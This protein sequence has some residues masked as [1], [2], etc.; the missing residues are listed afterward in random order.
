MAQIEIDE[1]LNTIKSE[2]ASN[3]EMFGKTL[4]EIN[5]KLEDIANDGIT[6]DL[7]KSSLQDLEVNLESRYRMNLEKF[8]NIKEALENINE[9]QE[10][11]TKNSDLKIMFNILTENID[12][13]GQEIN[14]QKNLINDVENK[15]IEFRNDNSKKDE[16][17]DKV[18]IVKDGI[19]EVN[20]GLQA[21]IMEVNSSLRGITK[22]LMTMD[23]TDQNDIIKRELENIYLATNAILSSMEILDQK[24]DD[25]AKNVLVKDDLI[26]L[27][28]KIDNSFALVSEKIETLDKSGSI[29]SEI[30]KNRDELVSF[31]ENVSK[32]LSEYLNSVRDV[33]SNCIDEIKQ[34]QVSSTLED[35]SIARQKFENLEKLSD[36]I[37]KIDTTI[38]SQSESYVTLISDKIR[39]L[40]ASIDD[41]KSYIDRSHNGIENKL[42]SKIDALDNFI[43]KFKEVFE[44]KFGELHGKVDNSIQ[45]IE[46]F[47]SDSTIKLG[48]S[49]SE[50]VDIKAEISRILENMTAFNSQQ[51]AN[52]GRLDGKLDGDLV[53]LKNDLNNFCGSFEALKYTLEQS[54]LDNREILTEIVDNAAQ[55]TRNIL[56]ELKDFGGEESKN[57]NSQLEILKE[58]VSDLNNAF[59]AIS[60]KNVENILSNLEA[61]FANINSANENLSKTIEGNFDAVRELISN[62]ENENKTQIAELGNSFLA[63][64]SKNAENILANIQ[65]SQNKIDNLNENIPGMLNNSLQDVKTA[66]STSTDETK[67]EI[68]LLGDKFLTEAAQNAGNILSGI[69]SSSEKIDNLNE[70]ITGSLNNNL[71]ELKGEISANAAETKLQIDELGS[72][73]SSVSSQNAENILSH[74]QLTSEKIT[75]LNSSLSASIDNSLSN[76]QEKISLALA[77]NETKQQITELGDKFTSISENNAGNIIA[78]LETV[79][80]RMNRLG[81]EITTELMNSSQN[82]RDILSSAGETTQQKLDEVNE[83]FITIAQ[84]NA[85]NILSSLESTS[86]KIDMLGVD[87][88]TEIDNNFDMVRDFIEFSKNEKNQNVVEYEALS[89]NIRN[90]ESEFSRN[91]ELFKTALD[92]QITSLKDYIQTLNNARNESKNALLF[93]KLAEKML[94][95]ETAIHEAGDNFADN[96][97][98]VQNKIADYAESLD[99]VSS[100]T[101][102]KFEASITEISSVKSELERIVE[103]VSN[104]GV[105]TA[106]RVSETA[107]VLIEKFDEIIANVQNIKDDVNGQVSGSLH[108]NASIID[109]KFAAIQ[110]LLNDNNLRNFDGI[111]DISEN[112]SGKIENLKQETELIKTDVSEIL[113]SKTDAI[114]NEFQPLKESI[115]N[116]LNADF[117]KIIDSIK[118]QIELSYLTFSADVNENLTENHDNYVQLEE[119]YKTLTDKFSKV[120]EIVEDLT[121][122]QIG[123]MT[124]TISEIENNFST[125]LE[126]TNTLLDEWKNDLKT[127]ENKIEESAEICKNNIM[128]ELTGFIKTNSANNKKDILEYLSKLSND[129]KSDSQMEEIINQLKEKLSTDAEDL[130]QNISSLHD[131]VDVLAM[132]DS[133]ENIEELMQTLQEKIED[134][135]EKSENSKTTESLQALHDKIDILAMSDAAETVES[136]IQTLQDKIDNIASSGDNEK[137][138]EMIQA[139]HDK[140]DVLVLS[141]DDIKL[142]YIKAILETLNKKIDSF[143]N[144]DGGKIEEMVKSLHDKM[145]VLVTADNDEKI[146][147]LVQLI[148]D[149]FE[150]IP[151]GSDNE[152]KIESMVQALHDKV[153]VLALSD[154]SEII[155]EIQ[156]IKDLIYEQRKQIENF[157]G[158]ERSVNVDN[159]LKELLT[160]LSNI[161][162]RLTGLDL[163]KNAA[164]IKDSVMN[165]VLSVADQISF[166]EETEEIKDFVEERTDEIN[167]NLLDVKKQLSNIT[168]GSDEWNY[169]Y[170]MQDIESDIA[171]L[172]LILNDI[173]ASTSKDDI[174][175]ISQNMHKIA[176]SINTLHSSLTEE[177]ILELKNNIEKINEDVLSLSSRTNKL[178]LTSDESYRALT[179]GLDEFSRLTSQLQ[180]RIDVLD[181]SGLNEI[182]EKKLDSINDAVVSSANSDNVM[183][184][185]MMY[186][187]EWIDDASEKLDTIAADSS[188]ISIINSEICL[189]KTMIDNTAIVESLEKK[190]NEQ[191]NRI[192]MLERK[193][194]EVLNA[195]ENQNNNK[196]SLNLEKKLDKL[197]DK[198]GKLSQGIEK[199]ASYVDEE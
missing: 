27:A 185:V 148:N 192:D 118:S 90:L 136:L 38:T 114:A 127:I 119:A 141:D 58:H 61:N 62:S 140:V 94:A 29:I 37:K 123:I 35:D 183:R 122:N 135:S 178:L 198:I 172:R 92:E 73:F 68:S 134:L 5:T 150:N 53:D 19:D 76:I 44:E 14:E 97:M 46:S 151:S 69:Q 56:N 181:N 129:I 194:D 189:L 75:E 154:E 106:E 174:N 25:L 21:S 112:I 32:G 77:D 137:M 78:G 95:I 191:Q 87:L 18:A 59:T 79:S 42:D 20:R 23:V 55:E 40:S 144:S 2:N 86:S 13:F 175:E 173:S 142:D 104:T 3:N 131:K 99:N 193:L 60:A 81:T 82:V 167:K 116:F 15:L 107:H 195:I 197:N 170:T 102:E 117:D 139:L 39:E 138:E 188:N 132:S 52:I 100:Q 63:E 130:K 108:K 12:N 147:D 177:Q 121:K 126:K 176:S 66:I 111:N 36:D 8:E 128:A 199:L 72:N 162:T 157:G 6:T 190:F 43:V 9:N 22:T 153:D 70:H 93:E 166:V 48:N 159:H 67:Q 17:I 196:N 50:I 146:E 110:E 57:I 163:E 1:I 45:F 65:N 125:N 109:E 160:D 120:E 26:N 88:S 4:E 168:N 103:N 30:Q 89:D 161:E 96:I 145:D 74:I 149:K 187:G 101:S 98:M 105:E 54:N 85:G 133:N 115:D 155:T 152:E 28:G 16:I 171:K 7:I 179:D 165:A 186:L 143:S 91:T 11:L 84:Q 31:N 164:D 64:A 113:A 169:S 182:I 51:E 33:L 71:N 80:D 34:T 41:F 184:Q 158:G 83:R 124:S 49:V 156:D 180:K 24:N 10:L 47:A